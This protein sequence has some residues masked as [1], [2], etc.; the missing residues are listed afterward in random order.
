[1]GSAARKDAKLDIA[2]WRQAGPSW[3]VKDVQVKRLDAGS[4]HVT[5]SA[6]LPLV[7]A[8]YT[9]TYTIGGDGSIGVEASY[10][11]G[12]GGRPL[13]MMP[14]FGLELVVSP[15][16]ERIAWYGRGPLETY[17]DRQFE[18]VGLYSSTVAEQ[19]VEYS[20]PQENG[21]K[22]D[23]RWV[24]L[25]NRDGLGLRAE[26]APTLSVGAAHVTKDDIEG[27]DYAFKLPRRPEVYLN[28]DMAQM[29]VG[30]V[31][32]WSRDAYPMEPYRIAPDK[33][34]A[35]RFRLVPVSNR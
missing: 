23:V 2:V 20:R 26:G 5:V 29:G 31:D 28:L 8:A 14:R 7:D 16:L 6:A 22:T 24:E 4:A 15:G 10:K 12:P 18:R 19:W 1:V 11:P 9:I 32:S 17:S 34:H 35:Y 13:A 25:T 21:N 27:T 3:S 30:G 33:A